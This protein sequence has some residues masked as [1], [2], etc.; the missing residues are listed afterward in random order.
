MG[1]SLAHPPEE[2]LWIVLEVL[3]DRMTLKQA[4]TRA[5]VSTTSISNWKA[6]FL[7]AGRAHLVAGSSPSDVGDLAALQAENERLTEQLRKAAVL[8]DVWRMSARHDGDGEPPSLSRTPG[9]PP[10]SRNR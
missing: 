9:P 3:A 7:R 2:K 4:A 8:V 6:R 5:G 1:R 10:S